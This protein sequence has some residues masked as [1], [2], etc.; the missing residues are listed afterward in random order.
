MNGPRKI[1]SLPSARGA[2]L[3][4]RRLV[5]RIYIL[6]NVPIVTSFYSINRLYGDVITVAFKFSRQLCRC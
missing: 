3:P 1:I 2:C 4:A 6:H 5:Q